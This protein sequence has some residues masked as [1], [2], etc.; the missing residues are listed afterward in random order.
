M[1]SERIHVLFDTQR[2]WSDLDRV[3][4]ERGVSW[5]L[6]AQ[7]TKVTGVRQVKTR[8]DSPRIDTLAPLAVWGGLSLDAY[9]STFEPRRQQ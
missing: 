8:L 4:Q 6:I 9:I 2:F 3:R 7:V 1:S 5:N